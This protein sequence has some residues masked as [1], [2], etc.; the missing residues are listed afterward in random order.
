MRGWW[1]RVMSGWRRVMSEW[2]RVMSGWRG[3]MSEWRRV[4]S[5]WR[6]VVSRWKRVASKWRRMMSRW[7]RVM[8]RWRR[9]V[10]RLFGLSPWHRL[11]G[12]SHDSWSGLQRPV[13]I[14]WVS[15]T[16]MHGVIQCTT[17]RAAAAVVAVSTNE[18]TGTGGGW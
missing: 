10:R 15:H 1:R 11:M 3:V 4:M 16:C 17:N 18:L 6:G 14:L 9:V 13:F 5:G 2:R 7:R 8:S 12:T